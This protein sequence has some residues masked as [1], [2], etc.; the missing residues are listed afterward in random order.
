MNFLFRFDFYL[1]EKI[2]P[3]IFILSDI[4]SQILY[5]D[6]YYHFYFY[7]KNYKVGKK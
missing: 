4:I 6:R 1:F 2:F 7:I 3:E 5:V